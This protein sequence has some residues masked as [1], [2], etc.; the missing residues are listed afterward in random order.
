MWNSTD[1][2]DKIRQLIQIQIKKDTSEK[3]KTSRDPSYLLSVDDVIDLIVKVGNAKPFKCYSKCNFPE[4]SDKNIQ[5]ENYKKQVQYAECVKCNDVIFFNVSCNLFVE[6]AFLM[7]DKTKDFDRQ[8]VNKKPSAIASLV[9]CKKMLDTEINQ[10]FHRH[11]F[12]FEED[13][14]S[15]SFAVWKD[16]N[17]TVHIEH[18][19]IIKF[20]EESFRIAEKISNFE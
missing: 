8:V 20:T 15:I 17:Q 19:S 5:K 9:T 18:N 1:F 12:K 13:E 16:D 6:H 4:S 2:N 11:L 10:E 3:N 14:E 7:N